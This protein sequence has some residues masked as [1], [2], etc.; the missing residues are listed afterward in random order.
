MYVY[1]IATYFFR[2]DFSA[3]TFQRFDHTGA[4]FESREYWQCSVAHMFWNSF[5]PCPKMFLVFSFQNA[6]S[7]VLLAVISNYFLLGK[8]G[9]QL[10]GVVVK[11]TCPIFG[12]VHL[13]LNNSH[14]PLL[15]IIV[16]QRQRTGAI[17]YHF[18]LLLDRSGGVGTHAFYIS[19]SG[20]SWN[21][22]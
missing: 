6:T 9:V 10:K 2:T 13:L 14:S 16:I 11:Q 3:L 4:S 19:A 8:R 22:A 15:A 17:R 5:I 20:M 1:A 18:I 21:R 12:L 7:S